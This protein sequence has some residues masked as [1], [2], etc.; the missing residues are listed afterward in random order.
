M[1]GELNKKARTVKEGIDSRDYEFKKLS[2]FVGQTINVDG[3]FFTTGKYGKAVVVVGN[4]YN[5]NMPSRAVDQFEV[6]YNDEQM[7]A[8]VL[9][10]HLQITNIKSIEAK[11]GKTIAYDLKDC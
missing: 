11:N 9:A 5:I 2:E 6:I 3:F 7:V 10:G 4:G 1:F 8:G